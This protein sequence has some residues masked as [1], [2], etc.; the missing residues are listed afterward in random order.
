MKK[1][2]PLTA[3]VGLAIVTLCLLMFLF[4]PLIAPY[5][6]EEIVGAPFDPP[7]ALARTQR[8]RRRVIPSRTMSDCLCP[9]FPR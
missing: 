8:G 7:S 5:G 4:G 9:A 2:I 1:S 6:Q 3:W